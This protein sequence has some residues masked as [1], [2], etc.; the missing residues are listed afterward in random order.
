MVRALGIPLFAYSGLAGAAAALR[1]AGRPVCA[2]F[3]ARNREVFAGCWRFP[4]GRVEEALAPVA[5]PVEMALAQVRDE[6]PLFTGDGAAL[7]RATI[8]K[9]FGAGAVVEPADESPAAGLLWLARAAPEMGRV[10]SPAAWEPEYL[11]A[12]GAERMATARAS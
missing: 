10:A 5:L 1:G 7:H 3:D 2:M 11:R 4:D 12:S 8:E 6:M 9:V